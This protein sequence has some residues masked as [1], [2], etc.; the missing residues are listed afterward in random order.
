M[1]YNIANQFFIRERSLDSMNLYHPLI[2]KLT[3]FRYKQAFPN[4]QKLYSSFIEDLRKT[5]THLLNL[6][7][8]DKRKFEEVSKSYKTFLHQFISKCKNEDKKAISIWKRGNLHQITSKCKNEDE[9]AISIWKRGKNLVWLRLNIDE[10]ISLLE[11]ELI[12]FLDE[13]EAEPASNILFTEE[14]ISHKNK[15]EYIS[16]N[17]T[18][19]E[20]ISPKDKA[21]IASYLFYH[22]NDEINELK[23]NKRR[24]ARL[25]EL[26]FKDL[27]NY[28][29][30]R[31]ELNKYSTRKLPEIS[32][33]TEEI[34]IKDK[35]HLNLPVQE[36]Q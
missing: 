18:N 20:I 32:K 35:I 17:M 33:K 31:A 12:Q 27:N 5:K 9:K 22:N 8:L 30:F 34:L 3:L 11:I 28:E 7:N 23:K 1:N 16:E 13:I 26:I 19:L 4:R 36:R 21:I 2:Y 10:F 6:R 29:S 14:F 24:F 25:L 15:Q